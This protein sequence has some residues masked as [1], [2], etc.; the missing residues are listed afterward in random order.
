MDQLIPYEIV[1]SLHINE[2]AG[3]LFLFMYINDSIN[4]PN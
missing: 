1:K 4:Y 3:F 2:M